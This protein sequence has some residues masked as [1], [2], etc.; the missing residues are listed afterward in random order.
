MQK[1]FGLSL[2]V[3][4]RRESSGR[5]SYRHDEF[6][7]AVRTLHVAATAHAL[8]QLRLSA[9]GRWADALCVHEAYDALGSARG[10]VPARRKTPEL[11]LAISFVVDA[12]SFSEKLTIP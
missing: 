2:F 11:E 7:H 4:S 6:F 5:S 3:K 9:L 10:G 12:E 8:H 1:G